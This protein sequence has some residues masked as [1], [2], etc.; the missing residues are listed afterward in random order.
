MANGDIVALHVAPAGPSAIQLQPPHFAIIT[1]DGATPKV[2]WDTAVA[3]TLTDTA[4][5]T[6]D[7]IEN[8][9][10]GPGSITEKFTG[11]TVLRIAPSGPEPGD[12]AGGTSREFVGTVVAIY[13]RTPRG[14]P[15]TGKDFLLVKSGDVFFEDLGTQFAVIGDR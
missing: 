5:S 3:T 11:K 2:L 1:L 10:T 12:P 4:P 8:A 14:F 7:I 9:P 15:G 6:L 13:R